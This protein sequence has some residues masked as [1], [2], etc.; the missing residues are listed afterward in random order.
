MKKTRLLVIGS[1]V[2]A[3]LVIALLV[4]PSFIDW[5]KYQSIVQE[6]LK[7]ATGYQLQINGAFRI[8]LLPTPHA[9]I[10][11]VVMTK[12]A[13]GKTAESFLTLENADV[14]LALLPLLV[15]KIEVS[16]VTLEKPVVTL[17]TYSDGT[18]NYMPL[19]TADAAGSA[20]STAGK[21]ASANDKGGDAQI[22][23]NGF[24]VTDGRVT[25][26]DEKTGKVQ[27]IG[28][29]DLS[30]KADSL[31]GP[32]DGNG[33]IR[34]GQAIFKAKATTGG[35]RAGE[36]LPVQVD[37][38]DKDGRLN[39]KWSGV[40]A[41]GDTKEMQGEAALSFGDLAGLLADIGMPVAVPQLGDK[42][43]V[44]GMLTVNP[45]RFAL[46]NG[47][48][49]SG[50]TKM[51][52]KIDVT[53]IQ[54][55]PQNIVAALSTD[56]YIDVDA[57][58]KVADKAVEQNK[59]DAKADAKKAPAKAAAKP[60]SAATTFIPADF[61]L[62]K[63]LKT[64]IQ[65]TAKGLSYKGKQTGGVAVRASTADGKGDLRATIAQ[66]PGGGDITASGGLAGKGTATGTVIASVSSL[67]AVLADWL[68]VVDASVFENAAVP[69]RID[70]ESDFTISG[71]TASIN[72]HP[73]SLGETKLNGTVSYTASARPVVSA[74]LAGNVL[75]LPGATTQPAAAPAKAADSKKAAE[76]PKAA[77]FKIDPPQLPFDVKFNVT[78]ARLVKGD[79][80]MTDVKAVGAYNGTGL[81]LSNAGAT[82]NGGAVTASGTV[83]DLKDLSGIDAQAGL[84]TSDLEGFVQAVTGQPLAI[85][86]KIGAFAG[87]VKAKGD[88]KKMNASVSAQ[89]KGFTLLASGVLDDPFSPDLPGTMNVSIKHPNFVEAVRMFSPGFGNAA[90]GAAKPI[91]ISGTAKIAGK[92]YEFADMKGVLGGSDIAG[93]VKADMSGSVPAIT[94]SIASNKLDVGALVGVDSKQ[95]TTGTS[96]NTAAASTTVKAG[97]SAGQWSREPLDTS[98]LSAMKLDI[99]LAANTLTY[100]TWTLNDAK[101]GV[102]MKDGTLKVS[103]LSGKLYGGGF[104]ATVNASSSGAK[105]PLNVA[106]KGDVKD[107]AIGTFLQALT[108]SSDKKADGTGSLS[109]DIKGQG[110]SSAALMASLAGNADVKA[111]ALSVYGMD[112]DKLAAN[113]V[114]AFDGGWKG[115][116][117]SVTTQGF[118]SGTTKFKDLDHNFAIA[119]GDMAVKDFKMETTS[120]N[121]ILL[122]N[123][124][125]SFARFN[126]DVNAGVQVTKPK[127]VPVIGLRLSGPLN[128]PQKQVNSAALDN[129]LRTKVGGKVQ[130]LVTDKLKGTKA[131]DVLNQFLPGLTGAAPAQAP[132]ITTTPATP[133]TTP[134]TTTEPSSAAPAATPDAAT[135]EAAPAAKKPS[136]KQ[137]LMNGLLNQLAR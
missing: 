45:D 1:S 102:D 78:L 130:D 80:V 133:A 54:T 17:V 6:K 27:D 71:N 117:A 72:F 128:D 61:V 110:T 18:D 137:E 46:T 94:A 20:N 107:V 136:A 41:T 122:A 109:F 5:S 77:D 114:E 119:G 67:K 132:A 35:Y 13:S 21:P 108:S 73:L 65:I 135:P 44:S 84:S 29:N 69:R 113:M 36:T 79:L 2:F 82:L 134:A 64:D 58:L 81:T 49:K 98:F 3:A 11:Q 52:A 131:G 33:T 37:V 75:T 57:W 23:V 91:D 93:S 95:V 123:G 88:S 96:A 53:G 59:K 25:I 66:I 105:A 42:T 8:A 103:P 12:P 126:M 124:T 90:S 76:A 4:I 34:Y 9:N 7:E 32:F 63:D 87:S 50:K 89:A 43:E 26:R 24:S 112:L 70:T 100:G 115:V 51:S 68:G 118:A 125:V 39:F 19:K 62:P 104:D 99:K 31:S 56:D 92:V 60:A 127:D 97:S 16:S 74:S 30:V 83:A 15:G 101:A 55:G 129:L 47:V 48:L 40:V 14:R 10:G 120:G 111:K 86:Q 22:S 116:L 38:A 85:G 28:I 106:F 121:A